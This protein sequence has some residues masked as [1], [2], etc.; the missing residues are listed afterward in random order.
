[1]KNNPF[2]GPRPFG[3]GEQ[4]SFHGRNREAR[5]LLSLIMAERAVLFYAQSGAGKTS[6]LNAQ[7]IP[8]LEEDGFNVL[9]IARVGG[10]LPPSIKP[11]GV[12]NVFVFSALMGLARASAAEETLADTLRLHTLCTFLNQLRQEDVEQHPVAEGELYDRPP[13]LILDQFEEIFTS[14]RQ[15]WQDAQGF[16]EQ[17]QEALRKIPELGVVFAMREDYVA[18]MDPYAA[19]LPRRL[20][21]RFRMQRLDQ[22]GA[23]RAVQ[24]PA[25][26]AGCAFAPGVAEKLVDDL[27]RIKTQDYTGQLTQEKVVLGPFVEPVQLQV[28]CSQLWENLPEQHDSAIQWEEVEEFGDIDQALTN[29]Y[30][31]A[32]ARSMQETG[33]NERQLRRWFDEQLITPAQTRGLAMRGLEQTAGLPN[34]AVDVLEGRHIIRTEVR[35]GARWYELSHDRLI[36][37]ILRSN[38]AWEAA[39]QTPLRLAARRWMDTGRD[40]GILYRGQTLINALAWA[41][42]HPDEVEPY[43]REFLKASQ[44]AQDRLKRERIQARRIRNLAIIS[45]IVSL[46]AAVALV[47]AVMQRRR[48]NDQATQATI[49]QLIAESVSVLDTHPRRSLLLALESFREAERADKLALDAQD[50][51]RLSLANAGGIVLHGDQNVIEVVAIS[52]DGRW[53]AAG[54][55]NDTTHLWDLNNPDPDTSHQDLRG[56]QGA[57]YAATFSHDSRWLFTGSDAGA[58][59]LWSLSPTVSATSP[60]TLEE[61]AGAINALAVSSDDRWLVSGSADGTARVWDL[62][63][64]SGD[65]TVLSSHQ[66]AINALAISNDDHWLAT[67]SDD[68]TAVLWNLADLSSD[69]IILRGHD[70]DVDS[71]ALDPQGRWLATGSADGTARL[72]DLTTAD[73]SADPVVLHSHEE[74]IDSVTFSPDGRWLV[75]AS[76]DAT[77]RLWDLAATAPP[78][79]PIILRGH[80]DQVWA[81]AVSSDSRWL[82]TGSRDSTARVWDLYASDPAAASIV[83]R[84]HEGAINSLVI[85]ADNRR[86]LTGS[87]DETV[88]LWGLTTPESEGAPTLLRG[89]TQA[90]RSVPIS[91]DNHWLVTASADGTAR[92]WDLTAPEPPLSAIVLAGHTGGLHVAAIH[93]QGR[94]VATG[95]AD[96]TARLWDL[97]APDPSAAYIVLAGH[98]SNVRALDF[99]PDGRWLATGSSDATA[100]LWDL[101]APD[102]SANSIVL[103]GHSAQ[104]RVVLF[105][106]DSNWLLTGGDD[107]VPRLW[108]VGQAPSTDSIPL[109]GHSDD[110]RAAAFSPDGRWL[111]TGGSDA[112]PLLWDLSAPDPASSPIALR[113]HNAETGVIRDAAFTPDSRWLITGSGDQTAI[114]WDVSEEDGPV[115]RFTLEAHNGEIRDLAVSGDGHWLLTGSEDATARLWDLTSDDPSQDSI[116][117]PGHGG[118]VWNV[119]I[120]DDGTRIVTSCQDTFARL[121]KLVPLETVMDLACRI[122]GRNLSLKEWEQSMGDVAYHE[123]C[124]NL[125]PGEGSP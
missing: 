64:P 83:L 35:A 84:G 124:P 107:Q 24:K 106:H 40:A 5:D 63:N 88:R 22:A 45:S 66:A 86:L 95:S 125:P 80:T 57:V 44:Q 59:F 104:I 62:D 113:G 98:T 30:E 9:P 51:L 19:L 4:H 100:R 69:P 121:W 58:V 12:K 17:V 97:S 118:P 37:P 116:V 13:L 2:V 101:N 33:V 91:Q 78:A 3:R 53:L 43:E 52:P 23:L 103:A 77:A 120:N 112:V 31:G 38:R 82:V 48:A 115:R 50:T 15:R 6:L 110:I 70:D 10:A 16:F 105:S 96:Q 76:V 102:P 87:A 109:P 47:Y 81:V 61:H 90:V 42:E 7:I 119:Y 14:H 114:V 41:E 71:V 49:R 89:H 79:S 92:L 74:A 60:I 73:P 39:R 123:T 75:T 68:D 26:Q 1:M 117:L 20:R 85:S 28:V 94:W 72:W 8:A 27:R 93:P 36:D 56:H 21:A 32:L 108:R 11:E 34:A 55:A 65:P 54:D 29:F 99:S 46:V 18:E 67:G 25:Q 122:A 111:M